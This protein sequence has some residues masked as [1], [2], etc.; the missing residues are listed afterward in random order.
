MATDELPNNLVGERVEVEISQ[1]QV[2]KKHW[3]RNESEVV[4]LRSR[5]GTVRAAF[6][7]KAPQLFEVNVLDLDGK[8]S[9]IKP[10]VAP[11][12]PA[13]PVVWVAVQVDEDG[14]VVEWPVSQVRIVARK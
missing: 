4:K 7:R 12:L 9:G 13:H 8:T 3:L 5:P 10:E 14:S 2:I 6:M 11:G 1:L